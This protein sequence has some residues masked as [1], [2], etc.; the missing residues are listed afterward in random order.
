MH[1]ILLPYEPGVRKIEDYS[2][3]PSR[4]E[5][6][7]FLHLLHTDTM[8]HRGAQSLQLRYV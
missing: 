6:G 1:L 8:S 3:E 2:V 4:H 7:A 5:I